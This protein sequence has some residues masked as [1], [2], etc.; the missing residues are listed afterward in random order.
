MYEKVHRAVGVSASAGD[1]A[2]GNDSIFLLVFRQE[3]KRE[4]D[5]SDGP[6]LCSK[7]L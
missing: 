3:R 1:H 4:R 6:Y 2:M 7:S 5:R